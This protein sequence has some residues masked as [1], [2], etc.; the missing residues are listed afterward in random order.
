M[1]PSRT[2]VVAGLLVVGVLAT[3]HRLPLKAQDVRKLTEECS[4]GSPALQP[5]CAQAALAAQAAQ[6]GLG[7]A[8][9]QGSEVTGAASTLG[10][11]LKGSPRYSLSVRGSM[12]RS[13]LPNLGLASPSARGGRSYTLVSGQVAGSVGLFDGF[14]PAPTVGGLLSLDLTAS[15]HAISAPKARGFREGM[16]GWGV[17]ARLGLLRESFTLPGVSLSG[18]YRSLGDNGVG[19]LADGGPEETRF[20]AAVSSLRVIAGKDLWGVGVSGGVGWDRYAGQTVV[21]VVGGTGVSEAQGNLSSDRFLYFASGTMTYVVL[22]AALELGWAQGFTGDLPPGVTGE[23][24]PS[25]GSTFG[26]LAFR[27]TF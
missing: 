4:E 27:L 22:Q 12:V 19:S 15:A 3:G 25:R 2:G 24:D 8:A 11:R 18:F 10:W 13:R 1:I 6:G 20:D 9:S 16:L 26:S 5:Q 14:S 21:R 23:F 17:G 7:L